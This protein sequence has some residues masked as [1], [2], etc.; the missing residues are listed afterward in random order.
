M[1]AVRSEKLPSVVNKYG[2][3]F[4]CVM[5]EDNDGNND[6]YYA[7]ENIPALTKLEEVDINH[8]NHKHE[9]VLMNCYKKKAMDAVKVLLDCREID[10][11]IPDEEGKTVPMKLIE[12][13]KFM[14][15][16]VRLNF[17]LKNAPMLI[18]K[19]IRVVQLF[20][21]RLEQKISP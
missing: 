15:L 20:I 12:D 1:Y 17:F 3:D 4:K 19:M 14:E 11:N 7:I 2:K 10:V 9:T 8:V 13:Q 18:N 16:G 6:L 5:M 21:M